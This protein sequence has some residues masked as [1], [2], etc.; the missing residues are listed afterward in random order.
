MLAEENVPACH[1]TRDGID[2]WLTQHQVPH[3]K[4]EALP[5]ELYADASHPLTAG[6]E[7]LAKRMLAE[8]VFKQWLPAK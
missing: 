2:A 7:M 6:Y 8:P 1:A 5:S 3:W 4:P